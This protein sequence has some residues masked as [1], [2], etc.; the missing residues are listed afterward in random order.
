MLRNHE[1]RWMLLG[2]AE[3]SSTEKH[4]LREIDHKWFIIEKNRLKN[5]HLI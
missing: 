2:K 3:K 5:F 1:F 4:T